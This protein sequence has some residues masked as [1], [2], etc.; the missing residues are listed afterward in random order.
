[1]DAFRDTPA[2]YLHTT[3]Q[4]ELYPGRMAAARN[5]VR[6]IAHSEIIALCEGYDEV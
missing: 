2:L 1:M 5:L 6:P 4:V 3:R